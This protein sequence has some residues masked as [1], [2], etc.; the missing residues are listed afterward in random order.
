LVSV[1]GLAVQKF[2]I[3]GIPV[4]LSHLAHINQGGWVAGLG[5]LLE[6][7]LSG[8]ALSSSQMQ[9]GKAYQA[10]GIARVGALTEES[11]GGLLVVS[12]DS[13]HPAHLHQHS[14]VP[15]VGGPTR[16]LLGARL[17]SL[18]RTPPGEF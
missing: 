9:H 2:S 5:C 1:S 8:L 17:I 15:G 7:L 6:K 14:D 4:T 18:I 12:E 10:S 3:L 16:E 13:V 11:L